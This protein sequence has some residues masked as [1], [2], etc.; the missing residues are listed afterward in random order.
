[1]ISYAASTA[2]FFCWAIMVDAD[3]MVLVASGLFA[4]AGA[5]STGLGKIANKK[6]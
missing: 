5:L 4:I 3:T 6:D 2:L 1:M